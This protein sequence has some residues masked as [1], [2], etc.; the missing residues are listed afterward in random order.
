LII[1]RQPRKTVVVD[2]P[3][4]FLAAYAQAAATAA[5][6]VAG[7]DKGLWAGP[8]LG[9][10]DLRALVGH[11]SR[12]MLTVL[13][14]L[15]RPPRTEDIASPEAYYALLSAQT[16]EGADAAAVVQRGRQAGEALGADPA[17]AFRDLADRAI[18][19]LAA[20]DPDDLIETIAGGIRVGS[21]V[22]T[23]TVELVVHGLDIAA[24]I[25]APAGF[26]DIALAEA[27]A[28]LARTGVELGQG[29]TLLAALTDR[30]PLPPGFSTV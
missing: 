11:T 3:P 10:W 14:Y 8:G 13:T 7:I 19:R 15:D 26:S 20:A 12:A 2:K 24:A 5:D 16:G 25:D 17:A 30:A 27:A 21:Y 22:P 6:V 1:P 4:V 18:A 9:E 28:V 23:R 29:P